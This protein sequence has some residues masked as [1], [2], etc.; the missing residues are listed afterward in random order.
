MNR[1]RLFTVMLSSICF[2]ALSFSGCNQSGKPVPQNDS[3]IEREATAV[4]TNPPL[5]FK[6][7]KYVDQQGTGIEAFTMLIPSDWI[8]DGGIR[9]V[10]DNPGMP[11]VAG[12]RITSADGRD[13]VEVFPNQSFF[14]TTNPM[15]LQLKPVGTKYFGAEVRQPVGPISALKNIVIKRFRRGFKDLHIVAERNL[16]ELARS[17]GAGQSQQGVSTSAEGASIRIEYKLGESIKEE[18]IYTVVESFS[19]PIQSMFGTQTNTM[20]TVGYIFSFKSD[21]GKLDEQTK[22]F[23]TIVSSFKLSPQW[24][25]KYNQVV[26]HLIRQQIQQIRSVGEL[27][28]IISRTHNEISDM[29]METYN[30]RQQVYDRLSENFSQHIRGVDEYYDPVEQRPVELPSGYNEGWVNGLGEYILSDNP[31]YNPNV[32]SNQTWHRMDKK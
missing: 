5:K 19:F 20:W 1:Q 18:E 9:W 4:Q 2:V 6:T 7:V 17:L 12:F 22:L 10:L 25:S 28:R 29:M 8:F 23:Q 13:E 27:S 3:S 24:F 31:N 15:T 16:P 32:G 30:N 26:E 14:W 21:K 11:A